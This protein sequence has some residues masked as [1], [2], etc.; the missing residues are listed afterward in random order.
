M[1][2]VYYDP[3]NPSRAVLL[4]GVR[5]F[6]V[7]L[8][9]FVTPFIVIAVF[10]IHLAILSCSDADA[11]FR[12]LL[13]VR[14]TLEQVTIGSSRKSPI[15]IAGGVLLISSFVCGLFSFFV[16]GSDPPIVI[17]SSMLGAAFASAVLTYAVLK[18]RNASG[19]YDIVF[20]RRT[21]GLTIGDRVVAFGSGSYALDDVRSVGIASR[22]VGDESPTEMFD[23]VLHI[24]PEVRPNPVVI[25]KTLPRQAAENL[26]R[27]ICSE[28]RLP[29]A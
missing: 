5:P 21:D 17:V 16:L 18:H 4:V 1:V 2:P 29:H 28:F 20:D 14:E 22:I 27:W 6:Q 7:S 9:L 19:R 15:L 23:V 3:A 24:E 12:K 10:L 26:R 25:G 11:N 13:F 8:C